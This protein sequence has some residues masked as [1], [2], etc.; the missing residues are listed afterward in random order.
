MLWP[1]VKTKLPGWRA[2][3]QAGGPTGGQACGWHETHASVKPQITCLGQV[4][5]SDAGQ[6]SITHAWGWPEHVI[7]PSLQIH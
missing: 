5:E 4:P 6:S 3:V 7:A 1:H 2:A